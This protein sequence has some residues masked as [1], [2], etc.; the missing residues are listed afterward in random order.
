MAVLKLPVVLVRSASNPMAVLWKPIVLL[1]SAPAPIAVFWKP[2]VLLM[3]ALAPLAVLKPPVVLLKSEIGSG[4]GV[5]VAGAL[6]V[7]MERIA[8][9]SCIE[10]ARGVAK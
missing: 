7:F 4:G 3:S 10:A 8:S 1:A 9:D 2:V 5:A 6:L